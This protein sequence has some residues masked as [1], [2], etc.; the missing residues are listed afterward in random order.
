[1]A[2]ARHANEPPLI[3]EIGVLVTGGRPRH[4]DGNLPADVTSFVGRKHELAAVKRLLPNTR[5]LTLTGMGGVGKTRLALRAAADL[6]RGF[7]DGVWLIELAG[8]QDGAL[9]TQTVFS[10][11]GLHD[12]A[13]AGSVANLVEFLAP[14][15]LL[16]IVDN[17]EH[18]LAD[19]AQLTTELLRAC[20]GLRILATTR[21]ALGVAGEHTL[22]VPP[23]ALPGEH[24]VMVAERLRTYDAVELFAERAAA[25]RPGFVVDES[26]CEA[27]AAVCWRLEGVP[28]AIELAAG[29]LRAL[30]AQQLLERLDDRFRV[31]TG[32][33]R[34]A[35]PRQQTLRA[36]IDW[37]YELCS[38]GEQLLWARLSAFADGF[39]LDAVEEVCTS[40]ELPVER[41]LDLVAGLVD[42]SVL[43]AEERAGRV[44]YQLPE[45]L[46]EYG[47]ELLDSSG[48]TIDVLRR[49]EE[50]CHRLAKQTQDEWAGPN[51][52][53][54]FG[55]LQS[56][57]GNVRA[58][59]TFCIENPVE[60]ER[61]I[62]MVAAMRYYWLTSG[63]LREGQRWM[64]R[65]LSVAPETAAFRARGL[66][67]AGYLDLM[68]S[69]FA[70]ADVHLKE[71][72]TLAQVSCL[73]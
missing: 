28:L 64:H 42:K 59:L 60:A 11:L 23:L 67:V 54:W 15:Q 27:V 14:R 61:G 4:V 21:Q 10:A 46:R 24:E 3:N 5:L 68:L 70:S 58:A 52:V 40:P 38:A 8:L 20:P 36:L 49:H 53:E 66:Y 65:L 44:R 29:R 47:L 12:R 35:L 37:S 16:L 41:V 50:W 30:S 32:G 19:C 33:S 18:V 73:S 34:T 62:E 45:T 57:H 22:V 17:C 7:V 56:D 63:R 51:Q 6:R 71:A 43:V 25:V 48:E 2:V 69:D 72:R 26:N 39:D 9:V 31:L 55:R 13:A 1:V